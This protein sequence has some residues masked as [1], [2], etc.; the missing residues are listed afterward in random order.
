MSALV[1][2]ACLAFAFVWLGMYHVHWI[3]VRR[4]LV[5][6]SPGLLYQS[7]AMRP[8]A[9]LRVV[10]RLRVHTVVDLRDASDPKVHAERAMLERHGIRHVNLPC[11]RE[12]ARERLQAFFSLAARERAAGRAMLVHCKDGEGR[13]VAFAAL[14][15]IEFDGWTADAAYRGSARL[16]P[17]LRFLSLIVPRAGLM[18]RSNPKTRMILD[19]RSGGCGRFTGTGSEA[20]AA[21]E[22]G[23]CGGGLPVK[24]PSS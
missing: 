10:R 24:N 12:P 11:G 14:Y 9:L 21:G 18:S 22:H 3:L 6:V 7:G 2:L 13:A 23:L 5:T 20:V 8:L 15:R 1:V 19:Y 17:L 16:P 4:R